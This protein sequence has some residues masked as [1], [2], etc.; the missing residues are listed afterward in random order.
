MM[1]TILN[2]VF[3][4]SAISFHWGVYMVSGE[5]ADLFER[6]DTKYS[7]KIN[8]NQATSQINLCEK[9]YS[10][11]L[12]LHHTSILQPTHPR[13]TAKLLDHSKVIPPHK[14]QQKNESQKEISVHPATLFRN[15]L[16]K[17]TTQHQ[18]QIN[19]T[20]KPCN[21]PPVWKIIHANNHPNN[22]TS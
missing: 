22:V 7:Q 21:P 13:K 11:N 3:R 12:A 1:Q 2:A 10:R 17:K 15:L 20:V 9:N 8:V 5:S 4:G 14:N 6:D 19:L 16:T 18:T